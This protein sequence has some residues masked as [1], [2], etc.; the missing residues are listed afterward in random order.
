MNYKYRGWVLRSNN[1][2]A[3]LA[4]AHVA[5]QPC[6]YGTVY[7]YGFVNNQNNN[8]IVLK[9]IREYLFDNEYFKIQLLPFQHWYEPVQQRPQMILSVP[10]R[11]NDAHRVPG[12]AIFGCPRT[13][14]AHRADR[15]RD[16]L[17]GHIDS[18]A[19]QFF[20]AV[21]KKTSR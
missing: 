11:Y 17:F 9:I 2:S 14:Q 1:V 5:G 3:P 16:L 8:D 6:S 4:I 19:V 18:G 15:I 21:C 7:P 12:L 10:V 20:N 13:A